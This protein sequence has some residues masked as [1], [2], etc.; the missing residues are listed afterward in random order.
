MIL[1]IKIMKDNPQTEKAAAAYEDNFPSP[2]HMD[3][4]SLF[5]SVNVLE[6]AANENT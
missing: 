1:I 2:N 3:I 6:T 4:S 5:K